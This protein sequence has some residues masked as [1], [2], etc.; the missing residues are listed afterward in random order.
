MIDF[1]YYYYIYEMNYM[2]MNQKIVSMFDYSGIGFVV[3][4]SKL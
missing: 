2:L 1:H 3:Y 4:I